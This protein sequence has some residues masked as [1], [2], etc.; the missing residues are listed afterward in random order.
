MGIEIA[1]LA[2]VDNDVG[3]S[4]GA[5]AALASR[6]QFVVFEKLSTDHFSY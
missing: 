3:L 2:R 5:A 1:R 4:D 6:A